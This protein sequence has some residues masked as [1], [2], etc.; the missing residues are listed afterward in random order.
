V[1]GSATDYID[2]LSVFRIKSVLVVYCF[3]GYSRIY[4]GERR[5]AL[6]D[7]WGLRPNTCHKVRNGWSRGKEW[8]N[9]YHVSSCTFKDN[10]ALHNNITS[11]VIFLIIIVTS[12]LYLN[13]SIGILIVP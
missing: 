3:T 10:S 13:I 11:L 1:S 2:H 9:A 8:R 5:I 4:Q 12:V 7:S 6:S